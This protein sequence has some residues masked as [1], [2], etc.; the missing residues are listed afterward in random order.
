MRELVGISSMD[1]PTGP[2]R[3]TAMQSS[4]PGLPQAVKS[5][6]PHIWGLRSRCPILNPSRAEYPVFGHTDIRDNQRWGSLEMRYSKTSIF[7]HPWGH[8]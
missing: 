1:A 8:P 4:T 6:I 7:R 5:L 3:L 2:Q